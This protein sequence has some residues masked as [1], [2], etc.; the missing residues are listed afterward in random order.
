M[1]STKKNTFYG[2]EQVPLKNGSHKKEWRP[3]K[4]MNSNKRND[5]Y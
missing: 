4:G 3:L 5:F 2:K 1:P